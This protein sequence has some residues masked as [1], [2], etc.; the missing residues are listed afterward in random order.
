[1]MVNEFRNC[2]LHCFICGIIGI[3]VPQFFRLKTTIEVYIGFDL[4]EENIEKNYQKEG[5]D[6]TYE[7]W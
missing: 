5:V 7:S 1:M 2:P 6:M 3:A 4:M